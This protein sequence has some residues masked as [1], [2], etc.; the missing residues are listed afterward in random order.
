MSNIDINVDPKIPGVYF[1]A[2]LRENHLYVDQICARK[3]NQDDHKGTDAFI[4]V[5]ETWPEISMISGILSK[6][7]IGD[8]EEL[9]IASNIIYGWRHS[10]SFYIS[11]PDQIYNVLGRRFKFQIYEDDGF[12]K[13]VTGK[14]S[15]LGKDAFITWYIES[16]RKV[17][18]TDP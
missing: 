16:I 13:D 5:L 15:E 3:E 12:E 8:T 4:K 7:D 1:N 14:I 6:G 10:I 17:S 11:L 18:L 9:N 2:R